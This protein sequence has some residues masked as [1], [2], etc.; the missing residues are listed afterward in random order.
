V[1][2]SVDVPRRYLKLAAVVLASGIAAAACGSLKMGAAAIVGDQRI[3]AASLNAEVDN[4][5]AGYQRYKGKIQLSYSESQLPQQVLM[6]IVRFRVGEQA[7]ARYHISVTSAD[8]DKALNDAV[9]QITQGAKGVPWDEVAVSLGLPPDMRSALGQWVASQNA[10][11]T[12]LNG[13]KP[14]TI[15]ETVPPAVASRDNLSVC[16][17]AKSMGI[18]INPQYGAIDYNSLSIVSAPSTLSRPAVSP[19]PSPSA[20]KPLLTPPC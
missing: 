1:R 15:F 11:L 16:R 6:W 5:S 14:T 2:R 3:S 20:S 10:L 8:A 19:A 12:R 13:G 18:Q 9:S 7:A 17:A 4:L